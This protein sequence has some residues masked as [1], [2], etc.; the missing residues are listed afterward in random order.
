MSR[1]GSSA[2]RS[3]GRTIHMGRARGKLGWRLSVAVFWGGHVASCT[4]GNLP[5]HRVAPRP[6]P[7]GF[8]VIRLVS[9]PNLANPAARTGLPIPDPSEL[10]HRRIS[11]TL[12]RPA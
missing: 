3:G 11:P 2:A 8:E 6:K 5:Y 4:G 9:H 10:R 1:A 7:K 12:P